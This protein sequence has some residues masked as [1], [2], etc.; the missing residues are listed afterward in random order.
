[1]TSTRLAHYGL[2][3]PLPD[4][5]DVATIRRELSGDVLQLV[6]PRAEVERYLAELERSVREALAMLHGDGTDA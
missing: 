1:M 5:R 3:L 4:A 6:G 2:R